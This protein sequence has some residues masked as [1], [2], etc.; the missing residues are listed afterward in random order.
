MKDKTAQEFI[1]EKKEQKIKKLR[2][3][4]WSEITVSKK[5]ISI[6]ELYKLSEDG[7]VREVAKEAKGGVDSKIEIVNKAKELLTDTIFNAI[8]N[9]ANYAFDNPKRRQEA[10]DQLLL[11]ATDKDL[12][13]F[14]KTDEMINAGLSA[15]E[16]SLE[17]YEYY[18]NLIMIA[19]NSKLSN[20]T[21]IKSAI[22]LSELISKANDDELEKFPDFVK[23]INTRWL[24]IAFESVEQ[25]LE[26]EEIQYFNSLLQ[27][28]EEK[29]RAA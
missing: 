17:N 29:R 26:K 5:Q 11:I 8:D 16:L 10:I 14:H 6:T 3:Q 27:F 20:L 1:E 9:L 24:R 7:K 22:A 28:I 19:N 12:K 23:T 18:D 13:M 25:K 15:I 2:A 21:N 4:G